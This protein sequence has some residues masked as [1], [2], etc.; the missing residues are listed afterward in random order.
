LNGRAI[1]RIYR[2]GVCCCLAL[3][4]M[5]AIIV[6]LGQPYDEPAH[7]GNVEFYA[8]EA[9]LPEVGEQGSTYESQ[10]GPGY[11]APSALIHAAADHLGGRAGPYAVRLVG[12]LLIWPAMAL[13]RR[14]VAAALPGRKDVALGAALLFGSSAPLVAVASSSQNDYLAIVLTLAAF[15]LAARQVERR[16]WSMLEGAAT[17]AICALAFL[18]KAHTAFV[19]AAILVTAFVLGRRA[20]VRYSLALLSS[21]VAL[22]GW[23]MLRNWSLYGDLTGRNSVA[24]LGLSFPPRSYTGVSSMAAWVRSDFAYFFTPGEYYRNDIRL[25][26]ALTALIAAV[27][28][29]GVAGLAIALRRVGV[30]K[31]ATHLRRPP[32]MLIVIGWLMVY[33]GY[34]YITW[35]SSGLSGRHLYPL[36]V[37]PFGLL[38]LG[39][40]EL[41]RT[42]TQKLCV[43]T[44]A[45]GTV[46]SINVWALLEVA[47]LPQRYF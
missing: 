43:A 33:G 26:T 18:T 1:E 20:A 21:F 44:L 42:R 3:G 17:G 25:P 15:V 14:L 8:A 6:P 45:A 24:L 47:S 16:S 12:V 5:Y 38:A 30:E 31:L 27:A 23:W 39:L 4:A 9:R 7:L 19:P 40:A 46:V 10:M 29:A 41:G 11:Y 37:V 35:N 28:L 2:V 34:A 13:T 22:S 36:A 32:V